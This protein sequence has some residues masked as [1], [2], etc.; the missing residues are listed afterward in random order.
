MPTYKGIVTAVKKASDSRDNVYTVLGSK[1]VCA[2]SRLLMEVGDIVAIEAM[3]EG[4]DVI[5]SFSVEG[6]AK[7]GE[8]DAA[9]SELLE[10]LSIEKNVKLLKEKEKGMPYGPAVSS[11]AAAL[12]DAASVFCRAYISGAP[13][14]VRFHHDGDGSSGAVSIHRAL[15]KVDSRLFVGRRGVS[16]IMNRG[17]EYDAIAFNAD[18]L[19]LQNY[20]SME[21]PVVLILD[22]GTAP[23]SETSMS[24]SKGRFNLLML[25]HHP[26]YK[27]F[28]KDRATCYINPWDYKSGTDFTAGL[29]A[30]VFAEVISQVDTNDMR[31]ASLISD[32][33]S[34]GDRKDK[35]GMRTAV[36]LDYLTNVA[37]RSDSGITRLTPGYIDTLLSSK[38]KSDE[39]YY[40][41]S[42][43]MDEMIDL[44]V[45]GA[46]S[47]RCMNG[48]TTF[49]L[50]FDMLPRSS[51]GWPLPG[52]YASRLQERFESMNGPKTLTM[53]YYGGYVTIRMSKEISPGVGILEMIE[54]LTKSVEYIE[55]GGGHNEA[56]SI[57]VKKEN[58]KDATDMVLRELGAKS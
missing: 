18:T 51:G 31:I 48:I 50:N 25:D 55:S 26:I 52:R 58:T 27:G 46:K 40:T 42:S 1:A 4:N 11:M 44:G 43:S 3:S 7:K 21:K 8:Y 36:I 17:I 5:E 10:E 15:S 13:I 35:K 53:I 23:G 56:A 22:F 39:I 12:K 29:L 20:E 34:Y 57:K 37:G 16:W 24:E 19:E 41:A 54:R 28:P 47:Y 9:V 14:I 6:R 45:R 33:S 2:K 49:V 30:S 38:E 32:F